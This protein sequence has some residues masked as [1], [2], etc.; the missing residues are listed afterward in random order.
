MPGLRLENQ[1]SRRYSGW[2]P[3][4]IHGNAPGNGRSALRGKGGS[5][6]RRGRHA[7][8]GSAA[9]RPLGHHNSCYRHAERGETI[10]HEAQEN[11]WIIGDP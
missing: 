2:T 9:A 7:V 1:G 5:R 11:S 3:I 6:F 4:G 10:R 8:T